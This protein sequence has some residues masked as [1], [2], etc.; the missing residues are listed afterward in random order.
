[1]STLL[2]LE[3]KIGGSRGGLRTD[4]RLCYQITE[5]GWQVA[6]FQES[7][8]E[9]TSPVYRIH[10]SWMHLGEDWFVEPYISTHQVFSIGYYIH[11]SYD[12]SLSMYQFRRNKK[13]V[14]WFTEQLRNLAH[15]V[16]CILSD[17]VPMV[18]FT[19]DNWEKFNS[20]TLSRVWKNI[21]AKRHASTRSLPFDWSIQRSSPFELQL[22]L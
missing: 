22:K 16:N 12:D 18:D 9:G 4:E 13:C 10:R 19:R 20:A 5:R 14:A 21:R 1:M 11:C 6:K 2:Y 15:C 7:L 3:R 17:N 8:Q